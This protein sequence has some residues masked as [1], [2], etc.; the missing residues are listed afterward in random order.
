M[1]RGFESK[2]VEQQQAEML[3]RKRPAG[4]ILSLEQQE[5]ERKRQGLILSRTRLAHQ[6]E[7]AE[8]TSRRQMLTAAIAELDRQL[9]SLQ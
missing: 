4:P 3:D 8:N 2:S 1:A 9:C 6:L 5:R 7:T